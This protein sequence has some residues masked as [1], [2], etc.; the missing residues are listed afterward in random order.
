MKTSSNHQKNLH[1]FKISVMSHTLM[2]RTYIC[3]SRLFL[4]HCFWFTLFYLFPQIWFF[5]GELDIFYLIL[6]SRTHTWRGMYICL[7]CFFI[8]FYGLYNS[9]RLFPF[10]CNDSFCRYWVLFLLYFLFIVASFAYIYKS[11]FLVFQW[12]FH[13]RFNI[14]PVASRSRRCR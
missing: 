3:Q 10:F 4:P 2:Y 1:K 5:Y 12:L 8:C 9:L 11:F 6:Q 7:W 14:L 13:D